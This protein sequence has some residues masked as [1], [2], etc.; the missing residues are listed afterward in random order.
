[1]QNVF[2]AKGNLGRDPYANV[3]EEPEE[4]WEEDDSYG[5]GR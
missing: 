4:L 1:M 2:V 3:D 5:R